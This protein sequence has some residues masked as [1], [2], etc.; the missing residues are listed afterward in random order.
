MTHGQII[1]I[2]NKRVGERSVSIYRISRSTGLSEYT[3]ARL[4]AGE[5]VNVST[6][7][8]VCEALE[9]EVKVK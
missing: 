4:L 9:L 1:E 7:I 3:I 8:K 5:N 6:L 2:I